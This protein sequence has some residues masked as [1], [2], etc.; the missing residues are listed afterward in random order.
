MAICKL[1]NKEKKL[2]NHN[3]YYGILA[4][5]GKKRIKICKSCSL[6]LEEQS[7]KPLTKVLQSE[8]WSSPVTGTLDTL[9]RPLRRVSYMLRFAGEVTAN[10]ESLSEHHYYVLLMATQIAKI[11]DVPVNFERLVSIAMFHDIPEIVQGDIPTPLKTGELK[12]ENAMIEKKALSLLNDKWKIWTGSVS[13]YDHDNVN[14]IESRIVKLADLL[15]SIVYCTEE[16]FLGSKNLEKALSRSV[17]KLSEFC[18]HDWEK[19]IFKAV[20]SYVQTTLQVV[21]L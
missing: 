10:P 20:V 14:D 19:E 11:I 15:S 9:F 12:K 6:T 17:K 13:E 21:I 7:V 3:P 4:S 8:V 1:C 18:F 16:I 2:I 5:Q